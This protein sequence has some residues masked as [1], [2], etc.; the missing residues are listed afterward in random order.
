VTE[1]GL[2][3]PEHLAHGGVACAALLA[4]AAWAAFRQRR[5]LARFAAAAHWPALR[6]RVGEKRR[7]LRLALVTLALAALFVA[8]AEPHWGS[9]LVVREQRAADVVFAVDVSRSMRARDVAPDRLTRARLAVLDVAR[10]LEGHRMGVVAFAGEAVLHCPLTLDSAV[11]ERAIGELDTELVPRGGTNL[12]Q[13]VRTALAAFGPTGA[14]RVVILVSDGVA[15]RGDAGAAAE[16]ARA[17]GARILTLGV[18]TLEGA[19]VIVGDPPAALRGPDGTPVRSRLDEE[20]LTALARVSGGAHRA[21]GETGDGLAALYAAELARLSPRAVASRLERVP[22]PQQRWPLGLAIL[23]LLIEPLIGE[24]RRAARRAPA[25]AA[26]LGLL[27][28][29]PRALASPE[30]A[31]DAYARGAYR[32]AE[33]LWAAAADRDPA[34]RYNQAVAAYRAGAFDDAAR[35][36]EAAMRAGPPHLQQRAFY[37][38]GNASYRLAERHLEE[39]RPE[40]ARQTWEA[41]RQAY[42]AALGLA[43][44]DADAR[45]NLAL[46]EG[47]LAALAADAQPT[48]E[49]GRGTG[50]GEGEAPGVEAEEGAHDGDEPS[51]EDA[52]LTPEEA[53]SLL[54]SLRHGERRFPMPRADASD[55]ERAW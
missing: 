10:E 27:A 51:P 20:A 49:P 26:A 5:R 16:D 9:H 44:D 11:L 14:E 29:A 17:A 18:G 12:E 25:L 52:S 40:A 43:R 28:L 21:L 19:P 22:H 33:R 34:L 41:A 39:G 7:R 2:A 53:L 3:R 47:R 31:E 54:E 13:A 6:A 45:H 48:H 35:A 32:E 55:E 1:L 38:L 24:R 42:R 8:L 23:L 15:L 37:G 36:F 4:L 30:R 46:T 50:E